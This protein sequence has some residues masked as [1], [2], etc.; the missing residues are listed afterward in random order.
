MP[1][2]KWRPSKDEPFVPVGVAIP[3]PEDIG[4]AKAQIVQNITLVATDWADNAQTVAVEG[5]LADEMTQIITPTPALASQAAY[6]KAGI[7]ATGQ[8]K[9]SLTFTCNTAPT[10]DL[11]VRVILQ[12][13]SI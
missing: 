11:V 7:K 2:L 12:G 4:A 1:V 6:Y 8:A 5:V 9:N 3:S 10:E 13:V